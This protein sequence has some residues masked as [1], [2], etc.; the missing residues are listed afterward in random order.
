M[1]HNQERS[2]ETQLANI[3]EE[4]DALWEKRDQLTEQHKHIHLQGSER[5]EGFDQLIHCLSTTLSL[6]QARVEAYSEPV[7][8]GRP[9]RE[10]RSLGEDPSLRTTSDPRDASSNPRKLYTRPT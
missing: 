9:Q 1:L 10:F 6:S 2:L 5:I 7:I 3:A 4:V 8:V